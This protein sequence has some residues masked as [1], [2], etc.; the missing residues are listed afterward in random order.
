MGSITGGDLNLPQAGWKGEADVVSGFQAMVNNSFWDN[1]YTQEVIDS[2][3]GDALL[4]IYLLRLERSL[5]PFNIFPGIRD[6]KGV[7]LEVE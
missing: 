1:G 3:R 5:I 6:H 2:I 7:L 4:D